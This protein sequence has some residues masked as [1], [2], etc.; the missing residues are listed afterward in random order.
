MLFRANYKDPA[1]NKTYSV[2]VIAVDLQIE[3]ALIL[4]G[5]RNLIKVDFSELTWASYD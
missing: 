3:K 2:P 1:D 4:H 5:K